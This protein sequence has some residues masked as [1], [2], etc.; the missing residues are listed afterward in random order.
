MHIIRIRFLLFGFLIFTFNFTYAQY[1]GRNK[2]HYEKFDFE[3]YQSPNFELYHYLDNPALLNELAQYSEQW[4]H[5]HQSVLKDTFSKKNPLIFYNDHADFQQTN[6]IS[7]NIGDGTGGVTESL[8]NRVIMPLAMT[9]Q[10]THHVLGHELVHAFQ[11]R[12]LINGDSTSLRSIA[13]LP[14][15]LVEGMAEY[16]SIGRVDAHTAMW[17]RDAV[18]NN[19][20]PSIKDL[21]NPRY[22]PYRY[23]QAFWAFLTGLY[24]DDI[25]EPFFMGT[26][27]YGLEEACRRVLKTNL[28]TLSGQW[29][30]SI[31]THYQSILPAK[32]EQFSGKRLL[33]ER[34]AGKLNISPVL[35]PNGRYVI[36]F[37]EKNLF[38]LD[39]FLADARSGKV[40]RRVA[41]TTKEGHIDAFKAIESAG[42]WSPN[43][44]SFAFTAVRK[45]QNILII[46]EVETGKTIEEIAIEGVPA[47]TNPAWAPDGKHILVS[48]LVNGQNDLYLLNLKTR[49]V[50]QL[51]DDHYAAIQ[52]SWSADGQHV[53]FATDRLSHKRGRSNGKW[54]FNLASLNVDQGTVSNLAIFEGADNLNPVFDH[55][56]NVL[57]VSDRDGYRNIY[58][59]IPSEGAVY[60]LTDFM[61]GV[62]GITKYAPAITAAR[63]RDRLLFSHYYNKGYTIYQAST[64]KLEGE[65]VTSDSVSYAAA[66]LPIAGLGRTDIINANLEAI[67]QL[68]LLSSTAFGSQDYRPQ[69]RLDYIGGGAGVGVGNSDIFG[70][71]AG[72]AGG[73]DLLFSDILGNNQLYTGVSL[74]GEIQDF[75]G[76]ALYIN[77][78]SRI[79]WGARLSHIPFRTGS[80]FFAGVD[81]LSVGDGGS[82]LAN[83][84][85]SDLVRIFEDQAGVFA[86]LPLSKTQRIEIGG[87]L[88]RYSYRIDRFNNYYDDFGRLLTRDRERL[89]APDPFML[90][91]INAAYVGDNSFFGIASPIKGHRYRLGV[92]KFFGRWDFYRLTADFRKYVHLKPFSLG[93]RALHRGN[94]GENAGQINAQ[95]VG[96]PIFVRGYGINAFDRFQDWDLTVNEL[97]GS[98]MFISNFEVRMPFTGPSQLA[99]IPSKFLFSE[100]AFFVDGGVAWNDFSDFGTDPDSPNTIRPQP[101]FSAGLSMRINVFGALILEPYYAI[102]LQENTRGVFG[103]NIVPG[104]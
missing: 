41:S 87:A 85:V 69:F 88:S 84:V 67:D 2:P 78:K 80:S 103:V 44:K 46:K 51:T 43:S 7:G 39:L 83:R 10:Q 58:K 91:S 3:V 94:Y 76:Q 59:Y 63:K 1:F 13:N 23:G 45:G 48:G 90:A 33:S 62:S 79:T 71:T 5:M 26:A 31:K 29:V 98:K 74:N 57:F 11:Y 20:I 18:L 82:I 73:V 15:W 32:R 36:F 53:I 75:G 6:T 17:M 40:I 86:Q 55:E 68:P 97:V 77:R 16:M 72:L 30:A 28:E 24:G 61:T 12:M 22:F 8:K 49:K 4:Y 81:T 14:L 100:L 56:Q 60:Q 64:E 66:T 52:P 65:L 35:S 99:L 25:I 50:R 42:T 93:F 92:E 27:K 101:I 54:T 96:N 104:W 19:D 95:Y 37:S 9:R 47:F 34:N 38:S 89:E 21:N 102:P 70:T